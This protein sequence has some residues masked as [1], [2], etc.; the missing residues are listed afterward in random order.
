M[1]RLIDEDIV[2]DIIN[3]E[4]GKWTGLSKTI[5]KEIKALPPSQPEQ[6]SE[7]RDILD[8]LDTVLHP[9]I[10]PEHWNV[11]SELH[12]MISGLP[13]AQ[14]KSY[15]EKLKEIA[16]ALSEKFAYMN[17]CL[18]ERD[19]ILGYLGVK[20]PSEI[21][22]NTDCTNIKCES[23]YCYKKMPPAQ[24]ERLTDDDFETI[25]IHLNAHKETLCNQRRW[26]EAEEYQHIIDRFMA[27][28][29][30]QPRKTGKWV[31]DGTEFGCCCSECGS[32]L[33]DYFDGLTE[34][35]RLMKIP[36]F[37]PNCGCDM[38]GKQNE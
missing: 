7:I 10:S 13:S 29:S 36:D 37:C 31:D 25:R 21:H 5:E 26:K 12:D 11:Y 19:I 22:C 32:T 1:G 34:D 15:K 8:Y 17:T 27:F 9:I 14:P 18:N 23:H 35:V 30:T 2:I 4:C 33:D 3:F 6:S 38:R 28:A 20:R 24:P 16:D